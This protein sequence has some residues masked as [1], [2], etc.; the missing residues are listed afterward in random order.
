MLIY[1]VVLLVIESVLS[2]IIAMAGLNA[3]MLPGIP[4]MPKPSPAI[5]LIGGIV[6]GLIGTLIVSLWLH[7]WVFV[8]GGRKGLEM[9]IKSVL[10]SSTPSLLLGWIP[11][12]SVIGAIWSLILGI[13]GIRELHE[14]STGRAIAAMIIAV[15]IP[16]II[17]ILALG[18]F[19]IVA[20][21]SGPIPV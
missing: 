21:S 13:Y 19:L 5:V 7:L 2:A 9:T 20:V 11:L 8:M 14:I 16:A 18:F 6:G 3:F 4:G 10:Y 15:V 12:V 1:F 17:F